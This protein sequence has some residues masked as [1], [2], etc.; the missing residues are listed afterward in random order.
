MTGRNSKRIISHRVVG[1][2]IAVVTLTIGSCASKQ[3]ATTIQQTKVQETAPPIKIDY[4]WLDSVNLELYH[5][6]RTHA[7][8]RRQGFYLVGEIHVYNNPTS[9]YAD[10]LLAILKPGLFLSEGV[11][12]SQ[13]ESEFF[14]KYSEVREEFF[15]QI[16]YGELGLSQLARAR[17]I[18]VIALEQIDPATGIHAGVTESEKA[19]LE[20]A[21]K[22]FD[23]SASPQNAFAK[24]FVKSVLDNPEG[25][26]NG[27]MK[28]LSQFGVDTLM[29]L[30]M[31]ENRPKSGIIDVRNELMTQAAVQY[32]VPENGCILIRFGMGHSEGMIEELGKFGCECEAQSLQAFLEGE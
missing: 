4:A 22:S 28:T 30:K 1:V 27:L 31:M 11:D 13:I 17:A 20:L 29:F 7:D 12:S 25:F 3:P 8:G 18:P 19:G 14:T 21:L 5:C 15:G 10:T 26:A 2:L 16:G 24:Q 32:I 6:S 23:L 9:R